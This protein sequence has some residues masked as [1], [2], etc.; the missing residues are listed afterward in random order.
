MM[1]RV[2]S[3]TAEALAKLKN[4]GTPATPT[5]TNGWRSIFGST[6]KSITSGGS[7]DSITIPEYV[8]SRETLEYLGFTERAAKKLWQRIQ[9][10]EEPEMNP[11]MTM[12]RAYIRS[13]PDAIDEGDD[14]NAVMAN[15][16]IAE[17]LQTA[18][19]SPEYSEIR[20]S[21][22]A[23]Y[24]LIDT[25]ERDFEFLEEISDRISTELSSERL[26]LSAALFPLSS[27]SQTTNIPS[28]FSDEARKLGSPLSPASPEGPAEPK[29]VSGAQTKGKGKAH[30]VG[31]TNPTASMQESPPKKP[32]LE[33]T[34]SPS[35]TKQAVEAETKEKRNESTTTFYKGGELMVLKKALKVRENGKAGSLAKVCTRPPT[36][37]SGFIMRLYLAKQ[38]EVANKYAGYAWRRNEGA[39]GVGILHVK[40]PT[41]L[42]ADT[43]NIYGKEWQDFVWCSRRQILPLPDN[44]KQIDS[45][46]IICG[47]IWMVPS[48]K[49]EKPT[50]SKA[51][52]VP[53][54]LQGNTVIQLG[55]LPT[56]AVGIQPECNVCLESLALN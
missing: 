22:T 46:P 23:H 55:L 44:L 45:A 41:R 39:R 43:V 15:I 3:L 47:P 27:S 1:S 9:K 49:A 40:I 54:E 5:E 17:R 20:L 48:A 21:E 37:L 42:L 10:L 34:P 6:C 2:P 38:K 28:M 30:A 52:V 31:S 18:I 35:S 33:T 19:M 32:Q 8:E 50:T 25:M 56:K 12:V 26:H 16:G 11:F 7:K 13:F 14:W 29:Q 24:W 36:D 53:Y 4:F 51:E